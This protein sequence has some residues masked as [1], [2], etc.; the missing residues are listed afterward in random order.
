MDIIRPMD[1]FPVGSIGKFED[2]TLDYTMKLKG[3]EDA[4]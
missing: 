1:V 3:G 4:N 2:G